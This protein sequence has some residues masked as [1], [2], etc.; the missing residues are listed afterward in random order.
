MTRLLRRYGPGAPG[1]AIVGALFALCVLL[2]PAP[3][4]ARAETPLDLDATG[5]ITDTVGALGRRRP[6]VEAALAR[7][8]GRD[9]QL[10]VTYVHDFSG[11]TGREWA[12]ATADRNGLGPHD[13]LLAVATSPRRFAVSAAQDSGF[14][15]DQLRQVATVAIAPALKAHDWAGAAIGAAD[16]YRS[17]LAGQAVRPPVIVPGSSD[18][19]GSGLLPGDRRFWAPVATGALLC[20]AG[21]L[22]RR[23]RRRRARRRV[24]VVPFRTP[25]APVTVS[26]STEPGLA[27]MAQPLTPLPDLETEASLNLVAT[28]DA[29][30]TSAEE[31]S[32]AVA[33]LG[34]AATLPFAEAVG[35]A[36]SEL[37][38]A[39]RLRQRLDDA[40]AHDD[41]FRRHALDEICSRCTSANR[42][43][44]AEAAAFDRLRALKANAAVVLARAE[45]AARALEPRIDAAENALFAL[46]RRCTEDAL[47]PVWR[48]PA[49][50]RD[51]LAFAGAAL[52]DAHTGLAEGDRDRAA[53]SVRAAEAALSQVRTLAAAALRHAHELNGAARRLAAALADAEAAAAGRTE[54]AAFDLLTAVRREA[55]CERTDPRAVLRRIDEAAA[56]FDDLLP[57]DDPGRAAR[58]HARTGR[59]LLAARAR[60]TGARDFITTH[61]GAVGARARTR[62]A[63]AER[64]LAL[65]RRDATEATRAE[66]LALQARTAAERDVGVY[67]VAHSAPDTTRPARAL[68]GALLGGIVL[69]GLLPATFGGGATR[70]RLAAPE[71]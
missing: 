58:S 63:E 11:R 27:R 26:A 7:L 65:A 9:V 67:G 33:Q 42:R 44:D 18:P 6:Q 10:Y 13:V 49:E 56:A 50:A 46:R 71:R 41:D 25:V 45:D 16:G 70:G 34:E 31:L 38:A 17:V 28:D 23:Q 14:R 30:R 40:P 39:F 51:R 52:E 8:A 24:T 48:Y 68:G 64:H 5:H 20:L 36:R 2:L 12:D 15:A 54:G 53:V 57:P 43:L 32:F 47:A 3:S 22:L 61:R 29:V 35:Y 4:V 19:G 21:L 62:L 69:A 37:A 55:T 1:P 60:V 66:T 59:A